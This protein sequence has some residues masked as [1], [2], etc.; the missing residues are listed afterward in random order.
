M[1]IRSFVDQCKKKE[2]ACLWEHDRVGNGKANYVESLGLEMVEEC[3]LGETVQEFASFV[4]NVAQKKPG[5]L[6]YETDTLL[7]TSQ[8]NNCGTMYFDGNGFYYSI[9]DYG[10]HSADV[11]VP[12]CTKHLMDMQAILDKMYEYEKQPESEKKRDLSRYL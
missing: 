1:T 9:F 3:L 5:L 11:Y 12:F 7:T 8:Q 10:C 6:Y 4:D 2:Y